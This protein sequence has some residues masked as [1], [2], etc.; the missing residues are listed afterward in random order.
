MHRRTDMRHGY[1]LSTFYGNKHEIA[2]CK[3]DVSQADPSR[4]ELKTPNGMGAL[5]VLVC[6]A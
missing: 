6:T 4:C 2:I 3:A 5:A 1:F